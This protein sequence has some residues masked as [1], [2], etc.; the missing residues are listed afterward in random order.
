[1]DKPDADNELTPPKPTIGD[2]AHRLAKVAAGMVVPAGGELLEAVIG[3]PLAKRMD[4]W[5]DL[6]AERVQEL[7]DREQA[8]VES[9]QDDP[10][11][12]DAVMYASRA[13]AY[14]SSE[15]KREA[16]AN[17]IYNAGIKRGPDD[18]ERL[19]FIRLIDELTEWHI[20]LLSFTATRATAKQLKEPSLK[21]VPR[22]TTPRR[23]AI[24]ESELEDY[25]PEL[26][27]KKGFYMQLRKELVA[28][29]L[30]EVVDPPSLLGDFVPQNNDLL[31]PVGSSD[32][33]EKPA[34]TD[35]GNALLAFIT[36][37][38]D[39]PTDA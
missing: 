4:T 20:R 11:F 26:S 25:Y 18:H 37:P 31:G 34:A 7:V 38:K 12:I 33:A 39:V 15:E 32:R 22:Q 21:G 13:A 19:A 28:C 14:T 27:G 17:A 6:I 5:R 16:L 1:M 10:Q 24:W 23:S 3:P 30:I 35:R 29:G 36:R 9:L 8:T 2:D